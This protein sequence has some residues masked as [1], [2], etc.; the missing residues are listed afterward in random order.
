MA[1]G[2]EREDPRAL[3]T[4]LWLLGWLA[5]IAQDYEAALAYAEECLRIALTPLDRQFGETVVGNSHL[6]LGRM[7]EGVE[8][9]LRHRRQA[10]PAGDSAL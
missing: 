10:E 6:L 9:V 3:G 4:A 7:N 1:F 2:R 8:T 5:I